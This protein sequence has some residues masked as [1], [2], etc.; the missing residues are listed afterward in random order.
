[1]LTPPPPPPEKAAH[2]SSP[3]HVGETKNQR[4]QKHQYKVAQ[5]NDLT[6]VIWMDTKAVLALSN[7]HDPQSVGIVS[8][9]SGAPL[10]QQVQVPQVIESYQQNMKGVDLCDQML[11]YY[12]LIHRSR[13]WWR[14]I[15]HH[16]C[17]AAAY[18]GYVIAKDSNPDIAAKEWPNFQDFIEDL[19][20]GLIG[21][22]TAKRE[23]PV[24]VA[25]PAPG[26]R[27]TIRNIFQ[28]KKTVKSAVC[29][30]IHMSGFHRLY[31]D[32]NSAT[33]QSAINALPTI[34]SE[35]TACRYM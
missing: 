16:L 2:T 9:R 6:F 28:K 22:T 31:K 14:R 1:M 11:G 18:N 12:A 5:K 3:T 34:F 10:Q 15:F 29:K 13:K 4:L 17:M 23:A 27:H 8:R 33:C 24:P 30:Q 20:E 32:V 35:P 19:A 21:E 25:Q 7:Y 26:N